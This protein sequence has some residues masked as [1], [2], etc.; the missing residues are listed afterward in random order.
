[1]DLH[2][3]GFYL[4][5]SYWTVRGLVQTGKIPVTRLPGLFTYDSKRKKRVRLEEGKASIRR[6][7]IDV[8]DLDKFIDGLV[9]E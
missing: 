1:M 2:Q 6:T 7:L 4:G 3:A 5:A 8:V 9:K